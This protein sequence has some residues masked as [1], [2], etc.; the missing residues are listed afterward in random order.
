MKDLSARPH[1]ARRAAGTV[2]I[3]TMAVMAPLVDELGYRGR[4]FRS[5]KSRIAMPLAFLISSFLFAFW[6]RNLGQLVATF[7]MGLLY[8][9]VYHRSGRLHCSIAL[10]SLSNLILALSLASESS[11][12]P[13][14]PVLRQMRFF[15]LDLPLAAAIAGFVLCL[16]LTLL[17]P[18][19]CFPV[20]RASAIPT[21]STP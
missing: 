1:P 14:I 4:I 2:G 16:G 3:L 18:G 8:A 20:Q 21:Q 19:I 15:L 12:L 17:I 13:Y 6:H 9:A 11:I 10:H 7:P 5:A